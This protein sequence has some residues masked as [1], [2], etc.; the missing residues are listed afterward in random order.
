MIDDT[1]YSYV[2]LC[3]SKSKKIN[4]GGVFLSR[5]LVCLFVCVQHF[6]IRNS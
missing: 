3:H 6:Q 5:L 2:T 4:Y 1:F